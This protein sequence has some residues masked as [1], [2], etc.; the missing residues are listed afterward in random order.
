MG[1]SD[2]RFQAEISCDICSKEVLT[3]RNRLFILPKP[4]KLNFNEFLRFSFRILTFFSKIAKINFDRC[5][6]MQKN[7][8][9]SNLK[10]VWLEA[11]SK[12]KL[13]MFV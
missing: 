5:Y 2:G 3:M 12:S 1:I 6:P 11:F 9:N 4:E 13:L 7:A 8:L 10:S